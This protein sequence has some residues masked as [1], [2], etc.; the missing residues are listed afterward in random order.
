MD[1]K[2]RCFDNILVERLWRTIKYE[3]VYLK[4]YDTVNEAKSGITEFVKFYNNIRPHQ[5][6]KYKTPAEI[7]LH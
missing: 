4:S 5:S 7:Y 2:G 1:G 6:L 3:E